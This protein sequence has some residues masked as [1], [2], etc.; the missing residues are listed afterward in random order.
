MTTWIEL[1]TETGAK[2]PEADVLADSALVRLLLALLRENEDVFGSINPVTVYVCDSMDSAITHLA[3]DAL[4]K[5]VPMTP[6]RFPAA[7]F[8]EEPL[9]PQAEKF[10][11]AVITD[12]TARQRTKK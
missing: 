1:K 7:W 2:H 6:L 11:R 10:I 8:R 12:F 4:G 5:W 9:S 3:P